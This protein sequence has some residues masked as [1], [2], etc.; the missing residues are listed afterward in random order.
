M[1]EHP[2]QRHA[3]VG[4]RV[5]ALPRLR[6]Q[7]PQYEEK[8]RDLLEL[9]G[10]DGFEKKFPGIFRAECSSA[11]RCAGRWSIEPALLMLD[12]PFAALDIFTRED[13][14]GVL[15]ISGWRAG[16]P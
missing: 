9:V 12:E 11:P 2:R 8:C 4:S 16:R 5:A 1:A 10:L 15:Q 3:A 14:W 6:K 13:L 7:R